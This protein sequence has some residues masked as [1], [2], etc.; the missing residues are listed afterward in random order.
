MHL[1]LC[2]LESH[3]LCFSETT[4]WLVQSDSPSRLGY[5]EIFHKS[6]LVSIASMWAICFLPCLF[7]PRILVH[8]F[9][10]VS[11]DV[12]Y[13]QI[14]ST[15]NQTS[16]IH[17]IW[18]QESPLRI[19]HWDHATSSHP[20]SDH[21]QQLSTSQ[22]RSCG[23]RNNLDRVSDTPKWSRKVGVSAEL[24]PRT[25]ILIHSLRQSHQ[26]C[27]ISCHNPLRS[28]APYLTHTS[29]TVSSISLK[30]FAKRSGRSSTLKS[31]LRSNLIG[32]RNP[33]QNT[34]HW[35]LYAEPFTLKYLCTGVELSC[36][37]TDFQDS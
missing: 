31:K 26:D 9:S 18:N 10:L 25:I 35:C 7:P 16:N 36:H 6:T 1:L 32:L 27:R 24:R 11:W 21:T 19:I 12:I 29:P 8:P 22:L 17:F 30:R 3:T 33:S 13:N 5:A 14:A 37:G 34:T 15:R 20:Q 23:S 4:T 28:P 2:L